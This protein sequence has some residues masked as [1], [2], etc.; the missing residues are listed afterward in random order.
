MDRRNIIQSF[1]EES[2]KL[3]WKLNE[4]GV[5]S[6]EEKARDD[7]H[8]WRKSFDTTFSTEMERL[9]NQMEKRKESEVSHLVNELRTSLDYFK[10]T[11]LNRLAQLDAFISKINV[12]D[13]IQLDYVKFEFDTVT[14]NINSLQM[15]IITK[16]T[17]NSK[18]RRSSTAFAQNT[19]EL[20]KVFETKHPRTTSTS[21]SS[22]SGSTCASRFLDSLRNFVFRAS[23]FGARY[24]NVDL[25]GHHK[26]L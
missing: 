8:K 11:N 5:D 9:L 3:R 23:I 21:S 19:L 2:N 24:Y 15:D 1:Q 25:P 4:L 26:H 13:D 22:S 7:V 6:I 20:V 17:D 14:K 16:V 12:D 18:R 10:E